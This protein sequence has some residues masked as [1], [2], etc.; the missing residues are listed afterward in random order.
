MTKSFSTRQAIPVADPAFPR[1]GCANPKGGGGR[2]PIIWPIFPENCM[3]M[4]KIWPRG[5]G[6]R[7]LRPPL[8]PPLYPNYKSGKNLLAT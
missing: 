8:D 7:P 4:K 5:G 1:G 3:K 6:A 2:Q